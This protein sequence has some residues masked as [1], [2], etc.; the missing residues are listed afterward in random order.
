MRSGLGTKDGKVPGGDTFYEVSP[1]GFLQ[2]YVCM[3]IPKV[4]EQYGNN[5]Y[6]A[7]RGPDD[8]RGKGRKGLYLQSRIFDLF[9]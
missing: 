2:L 6:I 4:L 3:L 1:P 5:L 9:Q 8:Q 7:G